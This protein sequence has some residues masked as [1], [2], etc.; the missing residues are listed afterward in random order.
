MGLRIRIGFDL[1]DFVFLYL[2]ILLCFVY[3]GYVLLRGVWIILR[4]GF[5]NFYLLRNVE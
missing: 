1:G 2:G 5:G 4:F 3:Y